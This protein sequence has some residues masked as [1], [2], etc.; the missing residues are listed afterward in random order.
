M[1]AFA[2]E[3]K[4]VELPPGDSRNED[5]KMRGGERYVGVAMVA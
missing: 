2:V 4:S 5:R 1:V 3:R